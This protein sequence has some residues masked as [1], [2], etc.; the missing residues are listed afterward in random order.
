MVADPVELEGQDLRPDHVVPCTGGTAAESSMCS[1]PGQGSTTEAGEADETDDSHVDGNRLTH[2]LARHLAS[3]ACYL[4]A[5]HRN[6]QREG[7]NQS[8]QV[9]PSWRH[10]IPGRGKHRH[11][12]R[13]SGGPHGVH[14]TQSEA[15]SDASYNRQRAHNDSKGGRRHTSSLQRPLEQQGH[16]HSAQGAG[17]GLLHYR[18][19]EARVQEPQRRLD[20]RV[21]GAYA[22]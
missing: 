16:L 4:G 10:E 12:S 22:R 8:L 14:L 18:S 9:P 5:F 19:A 20:P 15:D 11:R 17:T 3:E 2:L 21:H 13:I 1:H 6:S 7:P